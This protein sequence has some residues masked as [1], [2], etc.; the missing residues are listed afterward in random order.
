VFAVCFAAFEWFVVAQP[1]KP[2]SPQ[3]GSE[4]RADDRKTVSDLRRIVFFI[5]ILFLLFLL[6]G[7]GLLE[8]GK[9]CPNKQTQQPPAVI[10]LLLPMNAEKIFTALNTF[11][12]YYDF[13]IVT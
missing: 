11:N 10:Y 5:I 2:P 3:R 12:F 8:A 9:S 13:S 7:L 6:Y 4:R 1:E